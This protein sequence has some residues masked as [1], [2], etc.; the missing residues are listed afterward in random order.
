MPLIE[1]DSIYWPGD[2]AN[3][4][5]HCI[6]NADG[7]ISMKGVRT[8]NPFGD[9]EWV[10]PYAT[11]EEE[12]DEGKG[13]KSKK[14]GKKKKKKDKVSKAK[15]AVRAVSRS[16]ALLS[17]QYGSKQAELDDPNRDLKGAMENGQLKEAAQILAEMMQA[18]ELNDAGLGL[19]DRLSGALEEQALRRLATGQDEAAFDLLS[20]VQLVQQA[21][22][23]EDEHDKFK[24]LHDLDEALRLKLEGD[25]HAANH[26]MTENYKALDKYK[27]AIVLDPDDRTGA[28]KAR[29]HLL[30]KMVLDLKRRGLREMGEAQYRKAA[31]TFLEAIK[32]Q[33]E[34]D[35]TDQDPELP[36]LYQR[37]LDLDMAL[38]LKLQGDEHGAKWLAQWDAVDENGDGRVTD[39]CEEEFD[40]AIAKYNESYSYDR[41]ED[42]AG[43]IPARDALIKARLLRLKQKGE[44]D[45]L[46][47]GQ[48]EDCEKTTALA[49]SLAHE[50][51]GVWPSDKFRLDLLDQQSAAEQQAKGDG[52]G[53]LGSGS[54]HSHG[55]GKGGG[56]NDI[57]DGSS[58]SD[59]DSCSGGAAGQHSCSEKLDALE[60]F[61]EALSLD[62]GNDLLRG[63]RDTAARLVAECF[64][65]RTKTLREL[66]NA[67]AS[68][69]GARS[70]LKVGSGRIFDGSGSEEIFTEREPSRRRR[71]GGGFTMR[72]IPQTRKLIR[73]L[74]AAASV[75]GGL[76]AS[77]V[78]GTAQDHAATAPLDR[79]SLSMHN[80]LMDT[81]HIEQ[82]LPSSWVTPVSS[83][84]SSAYLGGTSL[85]PV[86]ETS[87]ASL[88]DDF[89]DLGNQV[90]YAL[91]QWRT[92]S[93]PFDHAPRSKRPAGLRDRI[94]SDSTD[95][96]AAAADSTRGVSFIPANSGNCLYDW[97]PA[98]KIGYRPTSALARA[99][100]L[101]REDF[102]GESTVG[103]RSS[104]AGSRRGA[105]RSLRGPARPRSARN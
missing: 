63:E 18:G 33:E 48:F 27:Q 62:P 39:E 56:G 76:G 89:A 59:G 97:A 64:R 36:E 66:S 9:A 28:A 82:V 105:R 54:H 83:S 92:Q 46:A 6:A 90:G 42:R 24:N 38:K 25:A 73:P 103:R 86:A 34:M 49:L 69:D 75:G 47:A 32:C 71:V 65:K 74:S 35:K 94:S 80:S 31:D 5:L 30:R 15:K 4:E 16:L 79:P 72:K 45:Q 55:E 53:S 19:R 58:G 11:D 40:A 77:V 84:A 41:K 7:S 50:G 8:K 2:D 87:V 1:G 44:A 102:V 14:K 99:V 51:G 81:S 22:D 101:T 104:S 20:S 23:G 26:V 98:Q 57:S 61:S 12:D 43:A 17:T 52:S 13:A 91:E 78:V 21:Y 37:C 60:A 70:R 68:G 67:S 96:P 29:W 85:Q 95:V 93:L 88:G 10:D 3:E 100:A